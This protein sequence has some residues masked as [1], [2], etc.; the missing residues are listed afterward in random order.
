MP[1]AMPPCNLLVTYDVQHR[2]AAQR[3]VRGV[4]GHLALAANFRE[5]S[6]PGIFELVVPGDARA[7]VREARELCQREPWRFA[8]THHWRPVDAWTSSDLADMVRAVEALAGRIRPRDAWRLT[9]QIHGPSRWHQRDLVKPLT[10][11]IRAGIVRLHDPA[12]ELRVDVIGEEAGVAVL[13]RGDD[14][15]IDGL[16]RAMREIP[17]EV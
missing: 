12:K 11:P 7:A 3:S 16:L 8:R 10:D 9:L 14:L 5:P 6:P 13:D 1:M 15:S 17:Q 4:L 2:E